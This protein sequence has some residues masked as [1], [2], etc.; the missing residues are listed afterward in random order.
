MPH[1]FAWLCLASSPP[2]AAGRGESGGGAPP[3]YI[4]PLQKSVGHP[5]P[6]EELPN[7]PQTLY[8]IRIF[9]RA[10]NTERVWRA[11]VYTGKKLFSSIF[12]ERTTLFIMLI[13]LDM[14]MF[15]VLS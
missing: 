10:H 5:D 6:H 1:I 14:P 11:V 15:I 3:L 12:L 13:H 9:S 8:T 7:V 4:W 2:A